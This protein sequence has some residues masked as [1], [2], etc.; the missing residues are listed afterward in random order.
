MKRYTFVLLLISQIVAADQNV[1]QYGRT[2]TYEDALD[3]E[4]FFIEN[5]YLERNITEFR[6]KMQNSARLIML[7][8]TNRNLETY[9][10]LLQKFN[11]K[12][13]ICLST[14]PIREFCEGSLCFPSMP[15]HLKEYY[16]WHNNVSLVNPP[17]PVVKELVKEDPA[18]YVSFLSFF[19]SA[20]TSS[21]GTSKTPSEQS[22][23]TSSKSI[24]LCADKGDEIDHSDKYPLVKKNK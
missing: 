2:I 8:L 7:Y 12:K 3:A 19:S 5:Q 14:D 22:S 17:T 16:T 10:T 24:E 1:I 20:G 6:V 15:Y 9:E 21:L 23:T 18:W 11:E 4:K 13:I